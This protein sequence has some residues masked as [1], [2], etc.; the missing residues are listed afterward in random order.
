M[1][2]HRTTEP[3]G[4]IVWTQGIAVQ[5]FLVHCLAFQLVF[6]PDYLGPNQNRNCVNCIQQ[7]EW[8][9]LQTLPSQSLHQGHYQREVKC[10]YNTRN[11]KRTDKRVR[12]PGI[13]FY[14]FWQSG[15]GLEPNFYLWL[16]VS[17]LEALNIGCYNRW[18]GKI[19]HIGSNW[20]HDKF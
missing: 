11:T 15:E 12:T 3:H 6:I 7:E 5:Y 16:Y 20:K 4:S 2:T 14:C 17:P 8:L 1:G 13:S 10:N 9:L 18:F 19:S